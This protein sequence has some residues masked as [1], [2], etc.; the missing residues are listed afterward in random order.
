M[1]RL[2]RAACLTLQVLIALSSVAHAAD[3]PTV[4]TPPNALTTPTVG[5]LQVVLALGL[6][7]AAIVLFGWLLRRWMPGHTAAG[8]LLRVVA[9]VMVGPK[10]RL[11][12]VEL[13]DQWLLLGVAA[14]SVNLLH[15][16][17]KPAT[18]PSAL[19]PS[20]AT[21]FGHVFKQAIRGRRG[22]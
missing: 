15:S 6:V 17:P 5:L 10:E 4:A 13:G 20:P 8:G 1:N 3:A 22:A 2:A 16:M 11:V 7:L 18:D 9:G 14:S 21:S 19:Q 12:L